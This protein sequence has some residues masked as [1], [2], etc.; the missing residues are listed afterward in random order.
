MSWSVP[1]LLR[2]SMTPAQTIALRNPCYLAGETV[3]PR[4]GNHS[5]RWSRVLT[6]NSGYE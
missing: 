3:N 5:G 2:A 6:V 4:F 1:G